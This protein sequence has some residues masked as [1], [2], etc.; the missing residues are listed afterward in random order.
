[1]P[2]RI[3]ET[4]VLD[5]CS[6]FG[7][8]FSIGL[9]L[10]AFHGISVDIAVEEIGYSILY[11]KNHIFVIIILSKTNKLLSAHQLNDTYRNLNKETK[12]SQ[13]IV[14]KIAFLLMLGLYF[15]IP[16]LIATNYI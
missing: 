6:T 1:M 16:N 3:L 7:L 10:V 12:Y 4:A 14:S 15:K 13:N 8:I 9:L 11:L 2:F 5:F